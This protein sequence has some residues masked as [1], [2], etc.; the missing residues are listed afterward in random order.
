MGIGRHHRHPNVHLYTHANVCEANEPVTVV[1]WVRVR[2]LEGT[3]FRALPHRR[4][5]RG[6]PLRSGNLPENPFPAIPDL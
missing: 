5:L 1:E 4:A 3:P 6:K 2:T